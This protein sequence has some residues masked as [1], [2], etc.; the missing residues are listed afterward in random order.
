MKHAKNRMVLSVLCI[1]LSLVLLLI[2]AW[3]TSSGNERITAFKL[4]EN[5]ARG[6]LITENMVEETTVGAY[7]M[8]DT[9]SDKA[10]LTNKYAAAD[11]AKGQLI[12]E[13]NITSD[14]IGGLKNLERL[15]GSKVAYSIS[16]SSL[17]ASVSG[18]LLSG[19]IVSVYVS[20]KEGGS[21]LP[22]ALTY[23]EVLYATGS[24]G[25]DQTGEQSEDTETVTLL[26]SPKQALQLTEYEYGAK[27]HL[28]LVY[29][30]NEE[31]AA[32]FL[33]KQ[34]TALAQEGKNE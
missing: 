13:E 10:A 1:A 14:S 29:R 17:A 23:V 6:S 20:T 28:G 19:D 34:D 22:P 15:D 5:V 32:L 12:F 26:V 8:S 24:D 18:K 7:G 9:V 25:A 3:Q 2:F 30:G 16:S 4:T 33:E 21:V 27:I 11:M 31:N